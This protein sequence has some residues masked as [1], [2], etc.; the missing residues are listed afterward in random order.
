MANVVAVEA[1]RDTTLRM[2]HRFQRNRH[3]ALAGTLHAREAVR[4]TLLAEQLVAV[5]AG[6]FTFVPSDVG[7]FL[8]SHRCSGSLL[9]GAADEPQDRHHRAARCILKMQYMQMI[10]LFYSCFGFSEAASRS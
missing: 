2:Q 3:H 5:G 6:Y 9:R 7:C 8:F 4:C 1:I 10:V